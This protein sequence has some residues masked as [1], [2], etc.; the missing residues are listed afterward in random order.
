MRRRGRLFSCRNKYQGPWEALQRDQIGTIPATNEKE[1]SEESCVF[2]ERRKI[3]LNVCLL[4]LFHLLSFYHW[5]L[6]SSF[7]ALL[8]KAASVKLSSWLADTFA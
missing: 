3:N 7:G 6:F 8:S 1:L 5:K 2:I 4:W